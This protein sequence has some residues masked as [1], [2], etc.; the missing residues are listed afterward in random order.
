MD[1]R[2]SVLMTTGGERPG[3]N[4]HRHRDHYGPSWSYAL[5][6]DEIPASPRERSSLLDLRNLLVQ[7]DC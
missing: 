1:Y 7:S 3:R 5:I 6:E 2:V 4:S